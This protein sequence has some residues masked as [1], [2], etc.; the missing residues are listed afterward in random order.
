MIIWGGVFPVI[1]FF[2]LFTYP[3]AGLFVF[4]LY[5]V[6]ILRTYVHLKIPYS[7]QD[8]FLLATFFMIDKFSEFFGYLKYLSVKW[9]SKNQT[10]IEYKKNIDDEK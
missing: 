6:Q 10:L 8:R 1:I 4:L 9:G 3:L 5:P 7:S 2:S